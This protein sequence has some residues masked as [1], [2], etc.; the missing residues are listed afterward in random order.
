MAAVGAGGS[1]AA[2]GQG[3]VSAGA[4]DPGA[5]SAAHRRLKYISLAVLVV[6]NA[7]LILSIRY[8][9]TLPGD[10][11]FA[12]TAVVMAEVLKGLTCLLLL[13][14]QKRGNVKHLV[15]FLHE[16]VL[17]QYVD[18]LKL[19]VP[20]L[21]YTLQN[22]LQYVAISNLPAATF[23][24]SP[25][26]SQSHS[27]FLCLRLRA[28]HSPAACRAATST[29]AVFPSQRPGHGALSAKVA[30]QGE[31]FLA[32]GIEDVALASFSLLALAQLG[33]N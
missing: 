21:I 25:R 33:P 12:T 30:H 3:A 18:T 2:A 9:R 23:Q 28:L 6:Q 29:S 4:L 1:T 16:A 10:R 22:N 7:S 32:A 27:F 17:V 24:P 26:C 13:F 8:A 15:L 19:A 31:G 14:A 5:A 20:S 11:F